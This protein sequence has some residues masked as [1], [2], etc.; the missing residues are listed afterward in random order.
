MSS[1]TSVYAIQ[2]ATAK[3]ENRQWVAIL[4]LTAFAAL[5]IWLAVGWSGDTANASVSAVVIKMIDTP[6][7]FQPSQVTIKVGDTVQ[8]DNVGNSV[9]HATSDPATR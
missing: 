5:A 3:K 9:H 7:S 4:T 1:R 8:W 2:M 6:P